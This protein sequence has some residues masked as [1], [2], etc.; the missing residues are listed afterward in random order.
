[1]SPAPPQYGVP[2][3]SFLPTNPFPGNAAAL[4]LTQSGCRRLDGR[5]ASTVIWAIA[6]LGAGFDIKRVD[7]LGGGC[8][9][10]PL[11]LEPP[12]QQGLDPG[13]GGHPGNTKGQVH[14]LGVCAEYFV[15]FSAISLPKGAQMVFRPILG[16]EFLANR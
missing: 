5:Q 14:L 11:D 13:G 9:H 16:A 7:G 1:M 3:V 2:A 6:K 12:L 15:L 8:P 4:P 10:P